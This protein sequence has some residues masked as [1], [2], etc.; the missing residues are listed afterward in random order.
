MS[1]LMEVTAKITE[2]LRLN[3]KQFKQLCMLAQ[4]EFRRLLLAGSD[5]RTEIL[6]RLFDTGLYRSVQQELADA[7]KAAAER[8]DSLRLRAAEA[9]RRVVPVPNASPSSDG[10]GTPWPPPSSLKE[11]GLGGLPEITE[12][13]EEQNRQDNERLRSL[14]KKIEEEDRRREQAAVAREAARLREEKRRR[15]EQVGRSSAC[16]E[17]EP[18]SRFK[19]ERLE[20]ALRAQSWTPFALLKQAR[21]QEEA[22]RRGGEL[23]AALT[24]LRGTEERAAVREQAAR[25]QANQRGALSDQ[26]GGAGGPASPV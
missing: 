6:R 10:A 25:E 19:A 9:C 23:D 13:L 4:G 24:R 2:I 21:G 15:L 7:A 1:K 3:Y 22:S 8:R 17:R 14:T 5:E 18:E 20:Q 12:A 26:P 11:D 16:A